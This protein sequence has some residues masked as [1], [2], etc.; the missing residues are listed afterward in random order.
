MK[1]LKKTA[2]VF[3]AFLVTAMFFMSAA[4]AF[5]FAEEETS[6]ESV[7]ESTQNE[8]TTAEITPISA[9]NETTTGN[10][11]PTTDKRAITVMWLHTVIRMRLLSVM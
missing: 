4:P 3:T 10:N 1:K 6:P 5:V 11:E 8:T 7:S 9:Q 2:A